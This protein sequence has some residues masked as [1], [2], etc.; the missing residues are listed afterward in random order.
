MAPAGLHSWTD[1]DIGNVAA[2]GIRSFAPEELRSSTRPLLDR[3]AATGCSRVAVHFDVDTA[4]SDEVRLGLGAEPA[5][6]TGGQVRL[7]VADID[8]GPTARGRGN[9]GPTA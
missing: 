1:D 9:S 3:L 4:D 5:G 6:L 2:W 8:G 7:I